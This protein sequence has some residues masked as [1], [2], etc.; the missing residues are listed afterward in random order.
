MAVK[1][2]ATKAKT[3]KTVKAAKTV[4]AEKVVKEEPV[5]KTEKCECG[6]ECN[7]C[8]CNCNEWLLKSIFYTLISILVFAAVTAVTTIIIAVD[9]HNNGKNRNLSNYSSENSNNGEKTNTGNDENEYD[10]SM[11]TEISAEELVNLYYGEEK[12]LIYIGRP[13]CGYCVAF[14]PS[15]Q[16]AQKDFG[17]QTYYYDI[18]NVTDDQ[19]NAI[20]GL[21]DFMANN[22]GYTPMVIVVQGGQILSADGSGEGWVGYAE[23]DAF[24]SYLEALGY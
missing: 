10:V 21:N 13:T 24:R 15:L 11:F 5:F 7:D 1:K 2:E 8:K 23:Y 19:Y 16:Q 4:K 22:F 17:Y 14:L 3:T 18:S 9:Y 6:C 12:S 20:T